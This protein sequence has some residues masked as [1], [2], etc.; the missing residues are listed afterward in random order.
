MWNSLSSHT[1]MCIFSHFLTPF[2]T[3]FLTFFLTKQYIL[4]HS[5]LARTSICPWTHQSQ[6]AWLV[7]QLFFLAAVYSFADSHHFLIPSVEGEE[8]IYR[9]TCTSRAM[10]RTSINQF[11]THWYCLSQNSITIGLSVKCS[12]R[13]HVLMHDQDFFLKHSRIIKKLF[14]YIPI[15]QKKERFISKEELINN[16][17]SNCGS[18]WNNIPYLNDWTWVNVIFNNTVQC[19]FLCWL[20]VHVYPFCDKYCKMRDVF[21]VIWHMRSQ[22][23]LR[24]LSHCSPWASIT[25]V[26]EACTC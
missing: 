9:W 21:D 11:K 17:V 24:P 25:N 3:F 7:A 23:L 8:L 19:F 10:T 14:V 5:C 6:H 18:R 22:L 20:C 12:T 26:Q 15:N 4:W 13:I 16:V 2:L 1:P